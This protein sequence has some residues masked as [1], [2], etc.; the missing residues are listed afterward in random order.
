MQPDSVEA[1]VN[2]GVLLSDVPSR[3]REAIEHLEFAL[4]KRPDLARLRELIED[5][6]KRP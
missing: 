6:K 3:S 4:A 1:R 2:L 5:V